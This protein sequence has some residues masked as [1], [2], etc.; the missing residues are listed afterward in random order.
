MAWVADINNS[1]YWTGSASGSINITPSALTNGILIVTLGTWDSAGFVGA[2]SVT[3][4]GVALT[5][6]VTANGVAGTN[7]VNEIWYLLNPASGLHALAATCAGMSG[8]SEVMMSWITFSGAHQTAGNQPDNTNSGTTSGANNTTASVTSVVDNCLIIS[9]AQVSNTQAN[10]AGTTNQTTFANPDGWTNSS[11][12]APKTPAGGINHTYS[13][14]D[15]TEKWIWVM[16]SFEPPAAAGTVVKDII[17]G[18]G[19]VPFPR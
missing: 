1:T 14:T 7:N 13:N 5:R 3:F 10:T 4:N 12:F 2:S 15:G 16:A 19:I 17:G 18:T 9:C 6:A 8:T 11:Y